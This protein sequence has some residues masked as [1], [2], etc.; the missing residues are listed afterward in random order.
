MCDFGSGLGPV[1]VEAQRAGIG[2]EV[3]GRLVRRP[4]QLRPED[5]SIGLGYGSDHLMRDVLL[6]GEQLLCA[7]VFLVGLRP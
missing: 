7:Q 6:D 3:I 1:D 5:D 4:L 2:L